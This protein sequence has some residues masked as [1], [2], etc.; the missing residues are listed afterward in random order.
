[1][2]LDPNDLP[3]EEPTGED[4]SERI[5]K[6]PNRLFVVWY[7]LIF[8]V[9]GAGGY[10]Y[11]TSTPQYSIRQIDRA[12]SN[13]DLVMFSKYVDMN[14]LVPSMAEQIENSAVNKIDHEDNIVSN[15]VGSLAEGLFE[16]YQPG[17][18]EILTS[19]IEA[20]VK[21]GDFK[22]AHSAEPDGHSLTRLYQE[23]GKGSA[24]YKGIEYVNKDGKIAI[25][26]VSFYLPKYKA[27]ILVD[28]KMRNHGNYW[29]LVDISNLG[30]V[31]D[32]VNRLDYARN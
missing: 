7:L 29:Q 12:V 6:I 26:G 27:T 18:N 13:H 9:V 8:V 19:E 1:M 4:T 10:W 14:N 16:V 3:A 11:W 31:M 23:S 30:E 5:E 22:S 2:D 21:K 17:L 20:Y 28:L 32:K 15:L 25:V 24:E